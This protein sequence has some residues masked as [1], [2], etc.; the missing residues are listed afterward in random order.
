MRYV[1]SLTCPLSNKKYIGITNNPSRR[2]KEHIFKLNNNNHENDYLQNH[3]NKYLRNKKLTYLYEV[4]EEVLNIDEIGKKEK[5]W[6]LKYKILNSCF[7]LTE[8]GECNLSVLNSI[9]LKKRIETI[10]TKNAHI[11]YCYDVNGVFIG[12]FRGAGEASEILN[13]NKNA[14]NNALYRKIRY[15]NY[16][17]VKKL[18]KEGSI[19]KPNSSGIQSMIYILDKSLNIIDKVI[20]LKKVSKKYNITYSMVNNYCNRHKLYDNKYYFIRK[21][22]LSLLDKLFTFGEDKIAL[23]LL[24]N[25]LGK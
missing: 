19:Y 17:F 22:D 2:K 3:F 4:I 15:K 11:I 7:N 24:D 18:Q 9:S 14:I 23:K 10:R 21:K 5:E 8:G 12:K 16:I 13:L 1:Y 20:G 25:E 6:I